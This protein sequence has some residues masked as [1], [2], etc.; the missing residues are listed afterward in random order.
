MRNFQKVVAVIALSAMCMA[1]P[2]PSD[3]QPAA[4]KS[5]KHA[6]K[7]VKK[8][9]TAEKL[10][11][12]KEMVDQQQAAMQQMQQQLQQTQQQLQQTQ[13]QLTQ[14]Q[15][16][17]QQADAKIATVESNSNLQVQKVG[18]DLSDVK[19]ALNATT[20]TVQKAEKRVGELEHP[21]SVAYKGIRITPGGFIELTGIYRSKATL[22]DQATPFNGIPLANQPNTKLSEFG[23]TARDSRIILRAD[24]DAGTTK[25]TGYFEMDFFGTSTTANPNQTSSYTP[26]VRQAWGRA[27]F[28]NGWTITGGQ[29]WNLITLNRKGTDADNA[30]LWIPNIMEA[31]YSVGYDWGR[32]AEFR[33]SKTVAKDFSVAVGLANAS[34]LNSGATSAVAGLAQPG[35][36]LYGNTVVSTCAQNA[37]TLVVTC[38]QTPL[39]SVNL[40]PDIVAKIAYDNAKL[41]HYEVKGLARIFRDRVV[42][43]ATT[44]GFNNTALGFGAGAGAIVPVVPKKVDFILQGLWGKGI[45]RYEDSGQFDF[46]VRSN[47]TG[48]HGGDNDMKPVM[49]YSVLAGFETHPTKKLEIDALFGDEYYDKTTYGVI[50][51]TT[52]ALSFAGYGSPTNVNTGCFFESAAQIPAGVSSTC[53]GNNKNLWNAKL[54]GYYDLYKGPI[55]TLRYG[56]EIDYVSRRTWAGVGGAPRGNDTTVFTTM[57]YIFP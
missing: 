41:G 30:N 29:M 18:S 26:R 49:S 37:T 44:A 42:P 4:K 36:G 11:Q 57:R 2:A 10:R 31:Q 6:A 12:L 45:S 8:D 21:N 39:Y 50:N 40:S 53:T 48:F 13:Q 5:A 54:Y 43:T 52:G 28:A 25:L 46:V 17:A 47:P 9:E 55:G 20:V 33:V 15:Q 22:S 16:T 34:Y 19:T 14:T 32:F 23:L 1:A 51:N 56:A 35:V 3:G 24:A 38:T 27:K 7:A